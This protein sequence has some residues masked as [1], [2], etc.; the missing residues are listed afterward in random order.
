MPGMMIFFSGC[1]INFKQAPTQN[2]FASS[3]PDATATILSIP[4]L[5]S[6]PEAPLPILTSTPT[7]FLKKATPVSLDPKHWKLFTSPIDVLQSDVQHIG[8]AEDGTMWFDGR[9]IYRY[10]GKSWSS[11][12]QEKIPAF[13]GRVIESL[14]VARGG[15][16]WFGTEKNEI[17]S[18]DGTTWTSQTVE[19]GGY[20]SNDI[21]S[22]VIRKNGELCAISIEGMSCQSAGKWTRYPIV[23]QDK[24]DRVYVW[25]VALTPL[26]EI[27]VPLSNGVLY[28]FDGKNWENSKVSKWINSISSS[29]DGSLWIFDHDGF[30]KRDIHGTI[31]YKPIPGIV[32]EYFPLVMKEAVDGTVWFGTGSGYQLAQYVNGSF[33]TVDGKVLSNSEKHDF[34]YDSFPFYHVHCIFQAKDGSMWFGTVN[35]IFRY[36]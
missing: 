5:T 7:P 30:G 35:G 33:V 13:R 27:W 32:W 8:Q 26:D 36:K 3:T 15:T 18:F 17:V 1:G 20:R 12:D 9:Q 2:S 22:I 21:V 11:Y 29:R 4:T 25:D 6:T 31:A 14:A 16:V 28:H 19:D 24:A 34:G 23:V 10:D